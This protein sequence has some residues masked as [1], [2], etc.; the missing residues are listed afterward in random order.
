MGRRKAE[1]RAEV[2]RLVTMKLSPNDELLLK[3]AAAIES[4]KHGKRVG[5]ST[6]VKR[7]SLRA[8][9]RVISG[10]ERVRLVGADNPQP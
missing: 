9:K 5:W 6:F 1:N 8:A 3:Q 10:A 7:V 4:E 2:T